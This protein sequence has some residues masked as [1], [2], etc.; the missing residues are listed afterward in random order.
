[1]AQGDPAGWESLGTNDPTRYKAQFRLD[2]YQ[3]AGKVKQNVRVITNRSNGNYDVYETNFGA[4]DRLIYSYNASND[5]TTIEN[6]GLYEQI[7]AG[8]NSQQKTNLDKST[9]ESTLKLAENNVSGGANSQSSKDLQK[10]KGLTGYKSSA[11]KPPNPPAGSDPENPDASGAGDDGSAP[12]AEY[13]FGKV[14]GD[15]AKVQSAITST[16]RKPNEYQNDHY[17]LDLD[18]T[19]Q[20]CIQFTMVEHQPQKVSTAEFEKGGVFAGRGNTRNRGG[21]ITLPIQPSIT[22]TNSVNWGGLDVDAASAL[23]SAAAAGAVTSGGEG[24]SAGLEGGAAL[25]QSKAGSESIKSAIALG[26]VSTNKNFFTKATGAIQN[27]NLELLFQ[28]PTLRQFSFTFVMSAREKKES[29]AIRRIIRFFKQGMS[30]KKSNTA[31][32]LK[33]PH[34]FDI[35]YLHK[36]RE[37]EYLNKIKECAL[38]NFSV[39]YTPAGNYSTYDNGAMTLYGLSMI[40]Q[41]LDPIYDEDYNQ[42]GT[43]AIGY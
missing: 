14:D 3:G 19:T 4:S 12:A 8:N 37:H 5:K 2:R 17:P 18:L 6:K 16:S 21:T 11:N 36:N 22:D 34:T 24:I 33:S 1:M 15:I 29:E 41:E 26:Y 32:F 38:I 40:F 27:P 31:L 13:D 25:L 7:F 35:K 39:D 23:I 10:L 42:F 20:D 9:K 28:G 30:V 43:E